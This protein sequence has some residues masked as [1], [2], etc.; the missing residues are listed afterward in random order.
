MTA[1]DNRNDEKSAGQKDRGT[2]FDRVQMP[3]MS[4]DEALRR[5]HKN[6]TEN[7]INSNTDETVEL[8]KLH[9]VM[10]FAVVGGTFILIVVVLL[11][12]LYLI[13]T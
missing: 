11:G 1:H 7:G 3:P 2:V 12:M 13:G 4:G 6:H 10:R 8:A 5:F 9:P